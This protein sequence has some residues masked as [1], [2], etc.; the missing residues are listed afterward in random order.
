M[1]RLKPAAT[2]KNENFKTNFAIFDICLA[3]R[4]YARK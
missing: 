1:R 3:M 2:K 4:L